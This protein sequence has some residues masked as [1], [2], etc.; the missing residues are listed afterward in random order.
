MCWSDDPV[1]DGGLRPGNFVR[2]GMLHFDASEAGWHPASAAFLVTVAHTGSMHF[3][4]DRSGVL[5]LQFSTPDRRVKI[6]PRHLLGSVP[7]PATG[8]AAP[9]LVGMIN[10]DSIIV[11]LDSE[12]GGYESSYSSTSV[13]EMYMDNNGGTATDA[14]A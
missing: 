14:P 1:I 9:Q 3:A 10:S 2:F 5:C 11:M 4:A 7:P 6:G 8:N 13:V 12:S